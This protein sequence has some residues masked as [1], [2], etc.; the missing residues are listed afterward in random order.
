M[1]GNFSTTEILVIVGVPLAAVCLGVLFGVIKPHLK[2]R[3][4]RLQGITVVT[5][6]DAGLAMPPRP[7]RL[8]TPDS[9]PLVAPLDR[10]ATPTHNRASSTFA[11]P[12]EA[13]GTLGPDWGHGT[14]GAVAEPPRLRLETKDRMPGAT[15]D[16][17]PLR[18]HRPADGTLQFLP[19]RLEIVEG[20]DLGHEVRFV[21]QPGQSTTEIT[22]GR[23][24]GVPY[25]HVQ[26]HEPTVSRIHARMTWNKDDPEWRITN[27]SGTNPMTVN[28][29]QLAADNGSVT[30]Q[31]G[32]RVE[33]GEVV[34]LYRAK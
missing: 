32:D 21:K 12:A 34:F 28:G 24:D 20:R 27:L 30:L 4:Q 31:D 11:P 8:P 17:P 10:A 7:T 29:T 26:L 13:T 3:R 23:Q 16:R 6:G 15:P 1:F 18:V 2:R 22:F 25:R 19:G 33:M 5:F 14:G 9:N